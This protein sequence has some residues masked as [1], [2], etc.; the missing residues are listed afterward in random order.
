[1]AQLIQGSNAFVYQ[2]Y[3]DEESKR[4]LDSGFIPLDNSSNPK[5]DWYEF[6]VILNYLKNN[7]LRDD[8]WYGF[9]SPRFVEKTGIN[10]ATLFA[11][12]GHA[13][14]SANVGLFHAEWAQIAFFRNPFEQG[15]MWHPGISELSQS[16]FNAIGMDVNVSGLVS[17]SYNS[18]FS[19]YIVAK[20]VFWKKWLPIAEKFFA[21]VESDQGEQHRAETGH[22]RDVAPMKTFV[23]ERIVSVI[24]AR[25]AF[26]V[27]VPDVSLTS[28]I[29]WP[30]K[31]EMQTRRILQ[32]CD[33][34][35]DR[36]C[37]TG[38]DIYLDMFYRLRDEIE[39]VLTQRDT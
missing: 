6:W 35:K 5:P 29:P 22:R 14:D 18:V 20:P 8:A 31:E 37:K 26:D 16:F 7:P 13:Q 39:L 28:P 33:I 4:Q 38:N 25:D 12:L 15:D 23:Q 2:I 27:V 21:F 30:F 3:Y 17:S 19:N 34:L 11:A 36:F 1:M 32:A 24:L 9:L 10:A